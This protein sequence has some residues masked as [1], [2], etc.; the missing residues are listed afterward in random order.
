MSWLSALVLWTLTAGAT[1]LYFEGPIHE[2]RAAAVSSSRTARDAGHKT[3]VIRR[4]RDGAGWEYLVRVSGFSDKKSALAVAPELVEALGGDLA[5]YLLTDPEAE[6]ERV[7]FVAGDV[8]ESDDE[9][10]VPTRDVKADREPLALQPTI[11]AHGGAAAGAARIRESE[12]VLFRFQRTLPDGAVIAHTW[13]RS[14]D[15]LFAKIEKVAGEVTPSRS[16]VIGDQAWLAVDGGSFE[17]KDLERTRETLDDFGPERVIPFVLSFAELANDRKELQI[18]REE[19][20]GKL[21]DHTVRILESEGDQASGPLVVQVDARSHLVRKVDFN[22]G[23]MVVEFDGW[24]AHADAPLKVPKTIRTWKDGALV[25]TVEI[26]EID[27]APEFP[28]GWFD[29]P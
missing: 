6:P 25:D 12:T 5:L 8:S 23:A 20:T 28:K 1:E 22:E 19:G 9:A 21:G 11:D 13:A 18:L 3:R 29:A 26:L 4:Y 14:G 17:S 10:D 24:N 27:L 7:R 16:K 2:D 15:D